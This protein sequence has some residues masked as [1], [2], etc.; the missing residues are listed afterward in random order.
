MAKATIASTVA[1]YPCYA[2]ASKKQKVL[3][4]ESGRDE[5]RLAMSHRKVA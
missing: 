4:L 1:V 3:A 5:K 2:S